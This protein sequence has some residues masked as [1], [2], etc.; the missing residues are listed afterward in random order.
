MGVG[1][2]IDEVFAMKM[3]KCLDYQRRAKKFIPGILID[4]YKHIFIIVH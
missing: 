3:D 1:A 4:N 2:E